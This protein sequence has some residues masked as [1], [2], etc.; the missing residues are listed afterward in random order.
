METEDLSF[1]EGTLAMRGFIPEEAEFPELLTDI[2]REKLCS[3]AP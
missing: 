1:A 3:K 2:T